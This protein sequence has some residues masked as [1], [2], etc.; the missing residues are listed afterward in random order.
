MPNKLS[1]SYSVDKIV[2]TSLFKVKNLY[3]SYFFDN[4]KLLSQERNNVKIESSR[5]YYKTHQK[6]HLIL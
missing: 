1:N 6:V 4:K 3:I 2:N 5:L